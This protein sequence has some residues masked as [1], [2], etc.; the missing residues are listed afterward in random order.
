MQKETMDS[1]KKKERPKTG[2]FQRWK[3]DHSWLEYNKSKW[4]VRYLFITIPLHWKNTLK[5]KCHKRA[6]REN[7]EMHTRASS[8]SLSPVRKV[9]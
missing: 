9:V 7:N 6:V 5:K 8:I 4:F 3:K 1:V 2:T